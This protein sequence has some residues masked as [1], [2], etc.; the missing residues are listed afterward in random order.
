MDKLKWDESSVQ[1]N[2]RISHRIGRRKEDM[3]RSRLKNQL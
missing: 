3:N 1:N 2:G